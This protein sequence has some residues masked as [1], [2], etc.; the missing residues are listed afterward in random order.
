MEKPD[1]NK[2]IEKMTGLSSLKTNNLKNVQES[3]QTGK[4]ADKPVDKPEN[5]QKIDAKKIIEN[6]SGISVNIREK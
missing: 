1:A 4:S 6:M 3:E 2:I 5:K